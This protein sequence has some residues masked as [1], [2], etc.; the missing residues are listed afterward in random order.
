M[1]AYWRMGVRSVAPGFFVC[2]QKISGAKK[3][4]VSY[5]INSVRMSFTEIVNSTPMP[6]ATVLNSAR[7]PGGMRFIHR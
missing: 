3:N 6:S 4:S 1:K 5:S 7:W 2:K